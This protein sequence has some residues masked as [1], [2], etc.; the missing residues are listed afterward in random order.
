MKQKM[1]KSAKDIHDDIKRIPKKIRK[2]P[3][4]IKGIIE[5]PK[6][7]KEHFTR[8]AVI[9]LTL[10]FIVLVFSVI[11]S[12]FSASV[13]PEKHI[14]FEI[15][16]LLLLAVLAE[17]SVFYLKQE[18]VIILMILGMI[19][20]P[21]F[22]E[23]LWEFL[24]GLNMFS[25]L[26]LAPPILFHHP[27]IIHIF[28]QLGAVILLF[29]VGIHSKIEKIFAK[30]NL[31]VAVSGIVFPFAAGYLYATFS[32]E[33]FAFSMF[34]GSCLAATSVGVTVAVLKSLGVLSKK[35]S[36]VIIGAAIID[37]IL[38]LIVLSMVTNLVE[39]EGNVIAS[40]SSTFITAGIFII[41]AIIT[42]K[43]VI[44]YIDEQEMGP[45]RFLLTISFM[46]FFS[47]V[48]EVIKLSAIVGAFLAGIIISRSKHQEEIESKTYGLELLFTPIFFI[49]L[50]SLV[51]VKSLY[52]FF[53]PILIITLIAV[54]SKTIG[55]GL[56]AFLSKMNWKESLIVGVG[57]V[58]RGE[59]ALIIAAI[60]FS[61]G[62]L[63]ENEYSILSAMA[64]L[65]SF[66][67]PSVL[68]FLIKKYQKDLT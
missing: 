34:V 7:A 56:T 68:A 42:G 4:D 35:F 11:R 37:D 59:V 9:I 38:G 43:Y 20:S 18:S 8:I 6:K 61:K 22:F 32:G 63:G 45:K 48:A 10:M 57:M 50:G 28:A 51:N 30:E 15:V 17:M 3:S 14:Y 26:P 29:K 21:S 5:E 25:A 64:L 33:S 60:G 19:I 52:Y 1:I 12:S 16:L 49:S 54:L 53:I 2:I 41:G 13:D 67:V 47:Y 39:A 46:L 36:D 65:T 27:E 24:H 23:L 55:A 40:I 31:L 62:I 44:K 66:L 58:P